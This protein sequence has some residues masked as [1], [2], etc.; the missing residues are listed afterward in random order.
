M[1]RNPKKLAEIL[2]IPKLPDFT[3][4][5]FD[6]PAIDKYC[7]DGKDQEWLLYWVNHY[8]HPPATTEELQ[9]VLELIKMGMHYVQHKIGDNV[10]RDIAYADMDGEDKKIPSFAVLVK[11]DRYYI[12]YSCLA[13]FVELVRL[14]P[15]E[16]YSIDHS[17]RLAFGAPAHVLKAG[18]EEA[19]HLITCKKNPELN[20][21]GKQYRDSKKPPTR[22]FKDPIELEFGKFM[23]QLISDFGLEFA[24]RS[25]LSDLD[26]QKDDLSMLSKEEYLKLYRERLEHRY[27]FELPTDDDIK[28]KER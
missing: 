25:I 12:N 4:E 3:Q 17:P 13:R 26:N 23:P 24:T 11:D 2:G 28:D 19:H 27:G 20:E 7:T 10:L 21:Q 22:Y 16:G 6:F 1:Y 15:W 8:S 5:P 9:T 18:A 14:G